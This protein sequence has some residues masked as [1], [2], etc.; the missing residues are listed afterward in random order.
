MTEFK[1]LREKIAFEKKERT[2]RYI[3]FECAFQAAQIAGLKAGAEAKPHTMIVSEAD[4]FTAKGLV[5]AKH[6]VV[7]EGPCGFAWVNIYPATSSFARWLAKN[8]HAKKAYEGGMQIWISEHG[9][10]MERKE[11][12]ARAMAEVLTRELGVTAYA[13]S[14]M[15]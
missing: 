5:G 4:S 3:K 11:A 6:W 9:Q 12:H 2:E 14:R 13:G 1:T 8:G 15:D 7:P 10:S